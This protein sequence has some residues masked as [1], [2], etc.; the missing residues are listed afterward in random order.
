MWGIFNIIKKW[1]RFWTAHGKESKDWSELKL[2]SFKIFLVFKATTF[3]TFVNRAH[4]SKEE[5]KFSLF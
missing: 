2:G 5:I 3:I 1:G 4:E